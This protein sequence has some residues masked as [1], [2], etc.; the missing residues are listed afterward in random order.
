MRVGRCSPELRRN[1]LEVKVKHKSN[2][3]EL[4]KVGYSELLGGPAI[5][6]PKHSTASTIFIPSSTLPKITFA[7]PTTQSWQRTWESGNQLCWV[8]HLPRTRC[9]DPYASG[10]NSSSNFSLQVNL[11]PVPF[12]CMKSHEPQNNK[13]IN[14]SFLFSAQSMKV[15][16]CLWNFVCKQLNG[17]IAQG[18]AIDSD[19]EEHS[20]V[21]CL[22]G[23]GIYKA[24]LY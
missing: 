7:I 8:Q 5:P 17:D 10:W 23:M 13:Q 3:L 19:V 21:D 2:S 15:F 9:P 22:G 11:S 24:K 16:H 12:W 18:L 6:G 20:G 1:G 14:K 4:S